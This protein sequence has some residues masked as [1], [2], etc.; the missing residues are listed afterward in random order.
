MDDKFRVLVNLENEIL[1]DEI[2]EMLEN[3][4]IEA[5]KEYEQG[6]M[7]TM[8]YMNKPLTGVNLEVEETDFEKA[9]GFIEAFFSELK[10]EE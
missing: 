10:I 5:F 6:S 7:S 1:A 3:N 2:I 8:I 9:K 4:G